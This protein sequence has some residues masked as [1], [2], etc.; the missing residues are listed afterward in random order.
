MGRTYISGPISGK[1]DLN[2]PAFAKAAEALLALG[3]QVINPHEKGL[4]DSASWEEHM[5]ADIKLLMD[6]DT[7][8]MLDGWAE[9]RGARI[10]Y[11][12]AKDLGLRVAPIVI[13]LSAP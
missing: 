11:R 13:L 1:P 12:L 7:V 10:E 4:P 3:H 5:R 2:K 8:A 6:C 9:S